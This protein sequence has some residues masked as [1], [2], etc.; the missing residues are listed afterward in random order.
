MFAFRKV[1][2]LCG[3]SSFHL[4][5]GDSD[6]L[7]EALMDI[8]ASWSEV[9]APPTDPCALRDELL[10]LLTAVDTEAAMVPMI[11]VVMPRRQDPRSTRLTA[12]KFASGIPAAVRA[13]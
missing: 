4:N 12:A 9:L 5:L 7:A 8:W 11:T 1:S 6:G 10:W 2:C 3:A 13:G